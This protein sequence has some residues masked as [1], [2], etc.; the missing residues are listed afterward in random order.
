[1][2]LIQLGVFTADCL[3]LYGVK[4]PTKQSGS[5]NLKKNILLF[6]SFVI[7]SHTRLDIVRVN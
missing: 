3:V 1:M 7:E 2:L 5:N 4:M 6:Q